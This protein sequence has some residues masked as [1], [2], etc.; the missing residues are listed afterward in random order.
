MFVA[1]HVVYIKATRFVEFLEEK[2]EKGDQ[3]KHQ[4]LS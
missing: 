4:S 2:C 1:P 3:K